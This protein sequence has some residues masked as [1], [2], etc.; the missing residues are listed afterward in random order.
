MTE[1]GSQP[2]RFAPL[3]F[4]TGLAA[5]ENTKTMIDSVGVLPWLR[6]EEPIEVGAVT[7]YPLDAAAT[8]IGDRADLLAERVGIYR[9]KWDETP[10]HLTIAIH[11][12]QL[13]NG[14]D[15]VHA[16]LQRATDILL[17]A[18]LFNNDGGMVQ[19]N[20]T[21]FSLAGPEDGGRRWIHLRQ[22]PAAQRQRHR[23]WTSDHV[24]SQA[25]ICYGILF[26]Q[27][28]H[29]RR[30]RGGEPIA[31]GRSRSPLRRARV[32]PARK[33]GRR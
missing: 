19:T 12:D 8:L 23:R 6:I 32:A 10:V 2:V 26:I 15:A 17:T 33:Y 22:E 3:R 11:A 5:G 9:E 20:A 1:F 27:R 16:D 30:T 18:A 25:F 31:A 24:H 7:F 29:S 4:E 14:G 13:A 28:T 21:T